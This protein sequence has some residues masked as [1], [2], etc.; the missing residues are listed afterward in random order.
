[1]DTGLLIVVATVVCVVLGCCMEV[2]LDLRG[3]RRSDAATGILTPAGGTSRPLFGVGS[4]VADP[5]PAPAP[6]VAGGREG[7]SEVERLEAQLKVADAEAS[8]GAE[9]RRALTQLPPGLVE[10]VVAQRH[11]RSLSTRE[12]W[13]VVAAVA[14]REGQRIDDDAKAPEIEQRAR[15]Y[16][17]AKLRGAD[18]P[19]PAALPDPDTFNAI[20]EELSRNGPSARLPGGSGRARHR[21]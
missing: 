2:V 9:A 15:A 21:R 16:I 10:R 20:A 14:M 5:E 17:E 11:G 19:I 8:E 18:V 1:M 13:A 12:L 4:E 3:A 6:P 7:P